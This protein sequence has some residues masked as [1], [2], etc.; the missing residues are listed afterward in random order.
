MNVTAKIEKVNYQ[1]TINSEGHTIL[2]DEL[3]ANNGGNTGMSP[4]QLLLSSLG[5]CIA[6]TLRMYST[7]KEWNV[8]NISVNLSLE[9][10]NGTTTI[11]KEIAFS[12]SI[13]D[14]QKTRLLQISN[15]C[16]ISKILL[17]EIKMNTI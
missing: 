8:G 17:G 1:V 9:S 12:E 6:I 4:E 5:S 13:S 15:S 2:S 10:G 7:R 14:E 11:N 3:L 16:P